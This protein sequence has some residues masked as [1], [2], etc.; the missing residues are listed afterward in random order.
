MKKFAKAGVLFALLFGISVAV[1]GCSGGDEG[2]GK[3]QEN[4]P[5]E[6]AK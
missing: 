2:M 6:T 4:P 5:S 1:I 3:K